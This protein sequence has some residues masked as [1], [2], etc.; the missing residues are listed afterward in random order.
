[1]MCRA[2]HTG[3]A[4]LFAFLF[5]VVF[6]ASCSP[7]P[8]SVLSAS[9]M[10]DILY[11]IHRAEGIMYVKGYEY[12]HYDKTEKYYEVVLQKNGITQAQ[13]DSSLVWYTDNPTRFNKIYPKVIDRLTKEKE[14]LAALNEQ[15]RNKD[16]DTSTSAKDTLLHIE[17]SLEEWKQILS[18]GLPITWGLDSISID[19]AFVYPY[20]P[21]LQ[22]SIQ[23]VLSLDSVAPV[24]SVIAPIKPINT[25]PAQ[26][27]KETP[28]KS[29]ILSGSFQTNKLKAT[30][31]A[32]MQR[33]TIKEINN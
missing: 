14:T 6:L 3:T 12:G 11:E 4:G 13:F 21:S 17:R 20:L 27:E 7:R 18:I 24:D 28:A 29:L 15:L 2:L 25:M 26:E 1:M 32:T 8:K 31:K 9:K 30:P 16:K 22:D 10:E 5:A 19:T 33:Q 23:Q